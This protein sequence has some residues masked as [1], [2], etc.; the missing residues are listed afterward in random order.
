[1]AVVI[2]SIAA[3]IL[4]ASKLGVKRSTPPGIPWNMASTPDRIK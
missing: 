4:V 2:Q 3:L 1:M